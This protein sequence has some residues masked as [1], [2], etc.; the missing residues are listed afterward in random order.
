M[1]RIRQKRQ[2][3]LALA[4][5][6]MCVRA[7]H[8]LCKRVHCVSACAIGQSRTLLAKERAAILRVR[9]RTC[10]HR[11]GAPSASLAFLCL[12]PVQIYRRARAC[13]RLCQCICKLTRGSRRKLTAGEKRE[14]EREPVLV[15]LCARLAASQHTDTDRESNS[16]CFASG[17]LR[18]RRS[19]DD[20][21]NDAMRCESQRESERSGGRASRESCCDPE[22]ITCG[23]ARP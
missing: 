16:C 10:A 22:P 6:L 19:R 18:T 8:L 12:L 17:K 4:L 3:E 15:C 20:D 11:Q 21:D 13:S 2:G 14:R 5:T 9:T 23:P 1:N 7:L